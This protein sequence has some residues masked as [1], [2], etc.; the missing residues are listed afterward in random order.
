MKRIF[1]SV[2]MV[3]L[4]AGLTLTSC[5]NKEKLQELQAQ[6]EKYQK[7]ISDMENDLEQKKDKVAS[8]EQQV[9][10]FKKQL[11]TVSKENNAKAS[12]LQTLKE[13]NSSLS[14]QVESI[15]LNS[16][17]QLL[18]ELIFPVDGKAY[19]GSPKVVFYEDI[20]LSKKVG[21]GEQINFVSKQ[22]K[23]V[24]ADPDKELRVWIARSESGLIFSAN[25]PGI[26]EAKESK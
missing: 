26:K 15:D 20:E 25:K 18:L 6:V 13:Q 23:E 24:T 5:G 4:M 17:G 2:V 19:V 16:D 8:L 21:T 7:E 10:T 22:Q 11:E 1:L 3:M 9:D 12:E 14:E